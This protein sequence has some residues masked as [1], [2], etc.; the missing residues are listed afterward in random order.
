M[1][2]GALQGQSITYNDYFNES[3]DEGSYI[4]SSEDE[5]SVDSDFVTEESADDDDDDAEEEVRESERAD[6][7]KAK[8]G[9]YMDPA[10]RLKSGA[11][12]AADSDSDS[13]SKQPSGKGGAASG[14]RRRAPTEST[15]TD[16]KSLRG[17]TAQRSAS[18]KKA[19]EE[20]ERKRALMPKTRPQQEERRLTQEELLEEAKLTAAENAKD[21]E[22]LV[23]IEEEMSRVDWAR[24]PITGP[25]VIFVST[26][27][28][29]VITFSDPDMSVLAEWED[30]QAP[31]AVKKAVCAITGQPAKY[32]DPLTGHAYATAAAF[33]KI[34]EKAS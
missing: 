20:E 21:L 27:A 18:S 16:R 1:T 25:R 5:D 32:R 19:A 11:K 10:K 6:K 7:R 23:R 28:T 34:R 3:S 15:P 29:N 26:K 17:S 9:A 31:I 33:K 12:A 24:A 14:G 2:K 8:K 13:D 22:R 30:A 4:E